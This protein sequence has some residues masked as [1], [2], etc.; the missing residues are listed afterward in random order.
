MITKDDIYKISRNSAVVH[1][2]LS[3][4]HKG[5]VDFEEA[6][7]LAVSILVGQVEKLES[8]LINKLLTSETPSRKSK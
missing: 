4:Y 1:S 5:D 7:M 3:S 6:M 2:C 8:E